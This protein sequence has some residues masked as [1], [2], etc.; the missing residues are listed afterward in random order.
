MSPHSP[1][2]VLL[3]KD[4]PA[5]PW[6]NG[7][8]QTRELLTWPA[9]SAPDQWQLRISRADIDYDGPFSAFPGVQR[10]FAVLKGAG[11][12]LRFGSTEQCLR[13]GDA[14]LSFDGA[15]APG[16]RL[17]EG[18]TQDLNLMVRGGGKGMLQTVRPGQ[19]WRATL[20]ACGLYTC[21]PGMWSDGQHSRHLASDTLLWHPAPQSATWQF[22]PDDST[23]SP[24]AYWLGFSPQATSFGARL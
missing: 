15:A 11:V 2:R 19:P 23:Q 8:G 21:A 3:A 5:M 13:A 17:L 22:L 6:R 24:N 7:G 20:G 12:A 10:W 1:A 9:G 4:C 14:P 16:C 18:R